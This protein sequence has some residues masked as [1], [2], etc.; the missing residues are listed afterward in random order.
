LSPR[1]Q[2]LRVCCPRKADWGVGHVLADDGGARV[3]VFFLGGGKRTLDTTMAELD[4]VT[5][6]A[7]LKTMLSQNHE[8]KP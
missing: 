3:A 8:V 5:G 6:P 2:R 7:A 4:L 1:P